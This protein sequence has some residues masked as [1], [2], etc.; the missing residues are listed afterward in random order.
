L[1]V[2][3]RRRTRLEATRHAVLRDSV[4]PLPEPVSAIDDYYDDDPARMAEFDRVIGA[5]IAAELT[6]L[7]QERAL[8]AVFLPHD[9]SVVSAPCVSRSTR[10][11][12]QEAAR[13]VIVML[14][15]PYTLSQMS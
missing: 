1:T 6:E 12:H 3:Q 8:H 14:G 5:E 15:T 9:N 2:L 4:L 7:A 13:Q 11:H 10:I